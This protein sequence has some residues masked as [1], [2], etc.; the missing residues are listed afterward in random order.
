MDQI[1]IITLPEAKIR[2]E[3]P[4]EISTKAEKDGQRLSGLFLSALTSNLSLVCQWLNISG[5]QLTQES[6]KLSVQG[7]HLAP[8]NGAERG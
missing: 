7:Y 6:G 8:L 1:P 3:S 2:L 4:P 5:N